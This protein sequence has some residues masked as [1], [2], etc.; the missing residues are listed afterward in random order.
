MIE[1]WKGLN[2][3]QEEL[4]ELGAELA[5][6]ASF[7]AGPHP[8]GQGPVIKRVIE[9]LADVKAALSYF[10]SVNGVVENT[11]REREKLDLFWEFDL[12]GVWH[13]E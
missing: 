4:N 12:P 8:D 9:E 3:L 1:A 5:R 6:L 11:Q 10:V 13:H 7:P 2:K